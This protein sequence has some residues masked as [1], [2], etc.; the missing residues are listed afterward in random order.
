MYVLMIYLSYKK[1]YKY[2][3]VNIDIC[4]GIPIYKINQFDLK[5][6]KDFENDKLTT[7]IAV[8]YSGGVQ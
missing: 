3:V 7:A 4:I 1:L 6:N 5:T 8:I 2:I